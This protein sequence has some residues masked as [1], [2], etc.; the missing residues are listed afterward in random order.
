MPVDPRILAALNAPLKHGANAATLPKHKSWKDRGYFA[1][2]GS[3]PINETCG[4]CDSI[5]KLT[6]GRKEV[7]K[8]ART[9]Q[10]RSARSDISSRSPACDGFVAR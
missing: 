9:R 6:V 1:E 8:C 7:S 4:S 10:T 3:G 5:L 2:P